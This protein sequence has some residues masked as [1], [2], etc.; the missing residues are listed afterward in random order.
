MN[1]SEANAVNTVVRALA[2]LPSHPFTKDMPT[3]EET[4]VAVDI[5][6]AGAHRKLMAGLSPG[7]VT[8]GRRS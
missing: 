2:G 6:L 1:I 5:L 3:T 4:Q 7:D 8:I